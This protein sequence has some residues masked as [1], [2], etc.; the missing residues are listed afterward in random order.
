L[1]TSFTSASMIDLSLLLKAKQT[2]SYYMHLLT[3]TKLF[4]LCTLTLTHHRPVCSWL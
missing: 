2:R 1:A 3:L 4:V